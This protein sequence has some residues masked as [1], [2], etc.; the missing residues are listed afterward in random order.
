MECRKE[1]RSLLK[2]KKQAYK[3][4]KLSSLVDKARDSKQF[5]REFRS[6]SRVMPEPPNISKTAWFNHFR[7]VLGEDS[8]SEAQDEEVEQIDSDCP[9]VADLDKEMSPEEIRSAVLHLKNNRS[10]GLDNITAEMLKNSLEET[11]PFLVTFFNHI[12]TSTFRT[13]SNQQSSLSVAVCLPP[14]PFN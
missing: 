11:L 13:P 4:R 2:T 7:N 10:P 8:Q 9:G 12:S 6:I 14:W 3:E 5:W 1:Y